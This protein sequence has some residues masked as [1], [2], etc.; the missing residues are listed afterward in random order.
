[1][2]AL[3]RFQNRMPLPWANNALLPANKSTIEAMIHRINKMLLAEM[4]RAITF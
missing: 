1:M 3:V 2:V 4:Y